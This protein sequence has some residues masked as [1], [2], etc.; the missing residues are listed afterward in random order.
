MWIDGGWREIRLLPVDGEKKIR[1]HFREVNKTQIENFWGN[2]SEE[3][4]GVGH[5]ER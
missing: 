4:T 2:W 1:E 5:S 3:G